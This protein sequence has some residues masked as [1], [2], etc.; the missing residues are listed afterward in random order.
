[1]PRV[2]VAGDICLR[3]QGSPKAVEPMMIHRWNSVSV[4]PQFLILTP[5]RTRILTGYSFLLVSKGNGET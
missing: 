5:K 3:T 2:E 1:M 4:H